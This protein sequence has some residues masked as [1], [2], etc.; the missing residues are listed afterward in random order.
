MQLFPELQNEI[1]WWESSTGPLGECENTPAKSYSRFNH[2][3]MSAFRTD[4]T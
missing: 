4:L 2:V 1:K 3:R